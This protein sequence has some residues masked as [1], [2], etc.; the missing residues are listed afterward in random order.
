MPPVGRALNL[1]QGTGPDRHVPARRCAVARVTDAG[2]YGV[3]PDPD[4]A[5]PVSTPARLRHRAVQLTRAAGDLLGQG[6]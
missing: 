6:D 1:R 2:S 5:P 3:A 4:R